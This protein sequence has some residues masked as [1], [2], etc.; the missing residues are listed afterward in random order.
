MA[1]PMATRINRAIELLA[2]GPGDL[3]RRPAHRPRAELRARTRGCPHLGRLHQRRHGARLLRHARACRVPAR[4]RRRRADQVRPPH[5]DR[6][7]RAAGAW[8]RRGERAQQRVAAA[9]DPGQGRARD[10]SVPGGVGGRRARPSWSRCATRITHSA[11]I[12]PCPRLS[13]GCG[14]RRDISP[15]E[16]AGHPCSASA[17][18]VVAPSRPPAAIWGISPAGVHGAQRSLATQSARRAAARRQA[19]EPGGR[20]ELRGDPG[21]AGARLCGNGAGRSRPL[22]GV[23]DLAARPL[24]AGAAGSARP[25]FRRL[26]EERHRLPGKLLA[27]KHR[28]RGWTRACA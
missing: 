20:G 4:P 14:G 25:R 23:S 1:G 17:R 6:D 22:A 7:R 19:R 24:P 9:P 15:E 2:A 13:S 8:H 27:G 28:P 16:R 11:S 12:Q 26:Q 10:R 18:A 3:L 21:R 5:A